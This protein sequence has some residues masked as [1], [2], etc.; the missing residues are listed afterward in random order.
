[1]SK[2][3]KT[4]FEAWLRSN[5]RYSEE[6]GFFFRHIHNELE[7]FVN[8]EKTSHSEQ[9]QAYWDTVQ[10]WARTKNGGGGKQPPTPPKKTD[11]KYSSEWTAFKKWLAEDENREESLPSWIIY[12]SDFLSGSYQNWADLY[13][14]ND[15]LAPGIKPYKKVI[16]KWKKK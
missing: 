14:V 12:T 8:S 10:E 16:E 13:T 2:Y 4:D 7:W 5:N 15:K 9:F 1:M 3:E 11:K 6:W